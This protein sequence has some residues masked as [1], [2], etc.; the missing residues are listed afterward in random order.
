M[1]FIMPKP[2]IANPVQHEQ[3]PEILPARADPAIAEAREKERVARGRRMG[4]GALN[5]TGGLG[6]TTQA[7]VIRPGLLGQ[8]AA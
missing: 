2:K 5:L 6:D 1:S 8:T 3:R 4:R 7:N